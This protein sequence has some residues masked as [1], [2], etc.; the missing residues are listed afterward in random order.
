MRLFIALLLSLIASGSTLMAS[1]ESSY[2]A[3]R[4]IWQKSKDRSDYQ[5]YADEFAKFNNYYHLDEK[6]GCYGLGNEP[7][8]LMLIITHHDNGKYARIE[9]VLS[10]ID[11]PKAKCF[12]KSYE[13]L[14]TKIPP[15]LPFVFQMR[16]GG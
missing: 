9:K 12:R 3:A 4:K 1:P 13:G 6:D 11:T 5:L 8:E 2:S 14:S 16:M 10:N 15:F 7:V